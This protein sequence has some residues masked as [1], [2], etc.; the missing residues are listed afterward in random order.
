MWGKLKKSKQ[1][2]TN[3]AFCVTLDNVKQGSRWS[4]PNHEPN[5]VEFWQCDRMLPTDVFNLMYTLSSSSCTLRGGQNLIIPKPFSVESQRNFVFRK[6]DR[7]WLV[8][9]YMWRRFA[10]GVKWTSPI[11]TTERTRCLF[12]ISMYFLL[13]IKRWNSTFYRPWWSIPSINL[14]KSWYGRYQ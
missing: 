13:W 12:R 2:G 11:R 3:W 8:N 10:C 4:A 1:M 7:L 14:L 9:N 5:A 6:V